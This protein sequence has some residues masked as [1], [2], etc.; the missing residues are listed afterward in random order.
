VAGANMAKSTI[1][2]KRNKLTII[3]LSP[4]LI[5]AFIAGWSLYC[6]GQS[7]Q[8]NIK[9]T[10]QQTNKTPPKQ[11]NIAL[12]VIPQQEEQILAN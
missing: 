4:F 10:Q 7:W 6:I 5:F 3:L 1:R 9:Q 11:D 8:K 2:K 12:T